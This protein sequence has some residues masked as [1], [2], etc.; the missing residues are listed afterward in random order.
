LARSI[1][2]LPR[3]IMPPVPLAATMRPAVAA[4]ESGAAVAAPVTDPAVYEPEQKST[5]PFTPSRSRISP[6]PPNVTVSPKPAAKSL[7]CWSVGEG[8]STPRIS[9]SPLGSIR[10]TGS[11]P[12]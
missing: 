12:A 4:P 8:I 10:L 2:F 5:L 11:A 6:V 3:L 1:L 7:V 9:H